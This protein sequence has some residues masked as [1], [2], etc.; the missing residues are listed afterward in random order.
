MIKTCKVHGPLEEKDTVLREALRNVSGVTLRCK[1]CIN[2]RA[3]KDGIICKTHGRLKPEDIKSN[4]RCKQCH[5][6]SANTKRN[7]NREWFNEKL[8]LDRKSNPEKWEKRYKNE[9]QKRLQT[10]GKEGLIT[11]EI[12]RM[13]GIT[14]DIYDKMF[15]EQNHKC[16]ICNEEETR[17][18]PNSENIMRLVVDHCH[19]TKKVRGLLCHKCNAMIGMARDSVDIL[20]SA[21][22]YLQ[23]SRGI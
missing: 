16:K 17:R 13:H 18:A 7:N 2:E 15:E 20:E 12:I 21:I 9:Y 5:R 23:Y 3:W 4:G 11:R 8:A 14:Q 22:I 19:E 1:K 10:Y 6:A